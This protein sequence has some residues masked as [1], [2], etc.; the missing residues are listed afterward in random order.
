M[1]TPAPEPTLE[2]ALAGVPSQFRKRLIDSYRT[3]KAA[4]SS[5]QHDA[6]GLRAGRFC[7][8]MLRLL[9]DRLTGTFIPFGTKVPDFDQECQKLERLPRTAGP[10]TLRVIMPRALAFLYTLRN[11]RGIGHAGGDVDANEI[12]AATM[13]RLADW[14]LCESIRVVHNLP[15]EEAQAILDAIAERQLPDVWAVIGKKRVLEPGFDFRSQTLLLLY[16]DIEALVPAEDLYHWI[17]YSS[18]SIFR[19]DVLRPLHTQRLIEFDRETDMVLISPTGIQRVETQILK[20]HDQ[21]AATGPSPRGRQRT[22][23]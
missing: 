13:V 12:D 6:S 16:S 10:E 14:C 18:L 23:R 15:L 17:E 2:A 3:L 22:P 19:R 4:Y 20:N 7:E 5:G 21:G 8:V 1:S 9:Q 11:K